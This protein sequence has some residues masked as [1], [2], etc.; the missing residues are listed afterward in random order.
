MSSTRTPT[1]FRLL[2]LVVALSFGVVTTIGYAAGPTYCVNCATVWNQHTQIAKEIETSINTARQ[3]ENEIKQYKEMLRQ[4]KRLPSSMVNRLTD[5]L[6][7]LKQIY[8]ESTAL[9]GSVEGF[10]EKFKKQHKD[11]DQYLKN[12]NVTHDDRK[13]WSDQSLDAMRTAMKVSGENV[14]A[15]D[16]E[17]QMLDKL[18]KRSQS[19][20]GRMQA[21]Q[22]GN[23]LIAQLIQQMQKMRQMLDSFIQAQSAWQAQ[24]IERRA[25]EDAAWE[26]FTKKQ[27]VKE[28]HGKAF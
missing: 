26:N 28:R 27:I 23:E 2:P 14:N 16:K 18:I 22:V 20:E 8:R 1:K 21:A 5:D 11:Y 25:R 19:A 24:Q 7:R 12:K 9:V 13:R 17:D 15:I 10:D 4:G 6:K 3:L